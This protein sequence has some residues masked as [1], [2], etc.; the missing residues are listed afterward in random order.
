MESCQETSW[1]RDASPCEIKE[2]AH[3]KHSECLIEYSITGSDARQ[4][5]VAL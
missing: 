2:N 3:P 1:N 5:L 4:D